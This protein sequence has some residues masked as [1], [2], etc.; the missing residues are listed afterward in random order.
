MSISVIDDS[1]SSLRATATDAAGNT[2]ACSDPV[3]YVEDSTAPPVPAITDS[4]PDSPANNSSPRLVGNAAA[5]ST[6]RIYMTGD[7]TGT[8]VAT[9]SAAA[10]DDPGLQVGAPANDTTTY[11]ASAADAAG[12][13]SVCSAGFSYREDSTSP[14]RPTLTGTTPAAPSSDNS[15]RVTG[16]AEAGSTVTL[17]TTNHCTGAA[18]ASGGAAA[19]G[20]P[21]LSV[22]VGSDQSTTFYATSTDAAGNTSACSENGVAY[23][24]DSTAP[25]APAIAGTTPVSPSGDNTPRLKGTADAGTTVRLYASADCGGAS[26]ASGTPAAFADPGLTVTVASDSVTQISASST[27]AAGNAT[28]STTTVT[29]VEDSSTPAAP[30]IA[31]F[32]PA[33][34]ANANTP[35]MS[36]GGEAGGTIRIYASPDCAG[37]VAATGTTAAFAAGLTLTVADDTTTQF[38]ATVT[39]AAGNVSG[40]SAA[41]TYIEDSTAPAAPALTAMSPASPANDNRPKITGTAEAGSTVRIFASPLCAVDVTAAGSATTLAAPGLEVLV[42]DDTQTTFAA[43]AIDAAGNAS[44]CSASIGYTERTTPAAAAPRPDRLAPTSTIAKITSKQK[45]SRRI[46]LHGT[47]DGTGSAVR[48]V[49]ISVAR[50][51]GRKCRFLTAKGTFSKARS[52]ARTT[53]LTAKGTVAWRI[54]LRKLPKGTY[55]VRSRATDTPGNVERKNASRNL[56]RFTL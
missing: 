49:G 14:D 46:T 1:T 37:A 34:P 40:C 55:K 45:R 27:D 50:E 22:T 11:H 7:C 15:P 5:G 41:S 38:S 42:A 52:C 33:S 51:L 16:S 35:K 54:A 48:V 30:A 17:Y 26:I 20:D 32:A 23:E 29:Y 28:C 39:D 12:N 8:A 4:S 19:F 2:S 9:G 21:G 25:A 13:A 44:P 24:E 47:A 43:I 53:Y 10:F 6:I 56:L 18:A 36:G 3:S 31:G